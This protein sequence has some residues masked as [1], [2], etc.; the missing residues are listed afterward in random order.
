MSYKQLNKLIELVGNKQIK[1]L[2]TEEIALVKAVNGK[3][4]G[5]F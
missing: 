5:G 4:K 3:D 2:T 1:D